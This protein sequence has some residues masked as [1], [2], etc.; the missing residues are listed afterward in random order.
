MAHPA[1]S[2]SRYASP[3]QLRYAGILGTGTLIGFILLVGAFV[4]Y[5]GG[6]VAPQV[7]PEELVQLWKQPVHHYLTVTGQSTGWGWLNRIDRSDVANLLGIAWL[8]TISIPALLTVAGMA[9]RQG[10]RR[11]ALLALAE[12]AVLGL[13]ASGI[14][15]GGH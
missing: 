2:S 15:G 12:V 10:D 14:L 8:A 4:V 3:E 11:F 5:L 9:L 6:W 7:Q 1:S 13:A